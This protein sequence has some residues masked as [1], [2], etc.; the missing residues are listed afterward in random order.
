[1]EAAGD[2][3]ISPRKSSLDL[4]AYASSERSGFVSCTSSRLACRWAPAA[5][6]FYGD[7]EQ[8]LVRHAE[9]RLADHG[10]R[11]RGLGEESELAR[12]VRRLDARAAVELAQHVA[13]VHVDRAGAEEQLLR[14]SRGSCARRR[15]GARPRA[16]GASGPRRRRRRPARRPSRA[17]DRLAER[18]DL[19]RGLGGQRARAE[20]ARGAVGVA[21]ALERRARARPPPRARRRRA[22]RSRR[23]RTGGRGRVEAR[24]RVRAARRRVRRRRRAAPSRRSRAPARRARR[25]GRSST[26]SASAPRRRR[27]RPARSPPRARK[28]RAQRRPQTRSGGPRCPP[29]ASS[30]ER[31]RSRAPRRRRPR[32]RR[33]GPGRPS[34]RPTC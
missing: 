7:F 5:W 4:R 26:R 11:I 20:L 23:A 2:A 25:G 1:M 28:P 34:C 3:R 13:H 17:A 18:G 10:L 31:Q 27:A 8:T 22:A 30:S 15:R 21:E 16:R 6:V 33:R 9:Q 19:A 32:R 24:R 14:R 29:S 12:P